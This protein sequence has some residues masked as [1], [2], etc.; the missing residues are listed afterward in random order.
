M[1]MEVKTRVL[2]T[3]SAHVPVN[4]SLANLSEAHKLEQLALDS[5][6]MIE[7]IFELEEQFNIILESHELTTLET[8]GD[9]IDIISQRLPA[10]RREGARDA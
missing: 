10:A 6:D 7:A 5:L 4:T 3:L 2:N 8:V 1:T 9:L